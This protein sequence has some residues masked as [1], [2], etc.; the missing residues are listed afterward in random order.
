[1]TW[2]GSSSF[3]LKL[4][5]KVINNWLKNVVHNL[6]ERLMPTATLGCFELIVSQFN[7]LGL[8]VEFS[9]GFEVNELS[10]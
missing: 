1:M 8:D 4:I 10:V 6:F 2:I 7:D 5:L 3:L 9:H